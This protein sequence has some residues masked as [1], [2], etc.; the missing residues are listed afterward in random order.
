MSFAPRV[1]S[2]PATC[3][4]LLCAL[5]G[6][7]TSGAEQADTVKFTAPQL[8]FFEKEVRPLLVRR[9][10]S[11]HSGQSKKLKG[12]LRLDT[13]A[14]VLHGGDTG[15]AVNLEKPTASLLIDAINYG[16]LYQMPPAG[17]LPAAE[18]ATLL[19]WIE[20][21]L[22]WPT[23]KGPPGT[24]TGKDFDLAAR[25]QSHWSWRPVIRPQ[26][27]SIQDTQWPRSDLDRFILARLEKEG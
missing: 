7:P 1:L 16:D 12:K 23:E 26:V 9:C 17:K 22:P 18:I 20:M 2:W 19:R 11:C 13:R 4:A 21:G 6:P 3:L 25:R 5:P 14:A 24:A 10:Y 27:P 15:P 8:E